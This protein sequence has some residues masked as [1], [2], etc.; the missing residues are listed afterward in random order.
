MTLLYWE[1]HL[2][3]RWLLRSVFTQFPEQLLDSLVSWG[4][5]CK[6]SMIDCFLV[7]ALGPL[8]VLSCPFWSTVLQ[9]GAQL[10]KHTWNYWT[11]VSGTRFLTGGVFEC[12]LAHCRS[13]ALLCML[14]KIRCNPMHPHY[15]D[16]PVPYVQ[17]Q[18]TRGA[19]IAHGYTYVPPCLLS[20][21]SF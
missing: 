19:V 3:P 7:D 8:G 9:C 12:D 1:C 15:G 6:Y 11:A 17:V 14:Y 21:L 2:I 13:V 20:L 18:V 10:L 16:L 5:P 4:S